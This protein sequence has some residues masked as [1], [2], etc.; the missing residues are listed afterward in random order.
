MIIIKNKYFSYK[1]ELFLF[2]AWQN[3]VGVCQITL[4]FI[5][6]SGVKA[7][8]CDILFCTYF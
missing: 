4:C 7:V 5:R 2:S 3:E 6:T 1:I 8:W